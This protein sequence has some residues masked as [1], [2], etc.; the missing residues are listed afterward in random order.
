MPTRWKNV[1]EK[2][3]RG[4]VRSAWREREGIEVGE[5]DA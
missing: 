5:G 4:F 1:R 2:S 3:E